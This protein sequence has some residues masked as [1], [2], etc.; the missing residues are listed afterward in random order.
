MDQ[1]EGVGASATRLVLGLQLC[2]RFPSLYPPC[3]GS[4]FWVYLRLL[5]GVLPGVGVGGLMAGP[6][7][8]HLCSVNER[9]GDQAENPWARLGPRAYNP[10]FLDC[11]AGSNR[12]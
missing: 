10:G 2:G 7:E 8:K 3:T 12:K 5:H 6:I 9:L 11:G 4:P 1:W